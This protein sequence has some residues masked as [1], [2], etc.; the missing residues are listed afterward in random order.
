[1]WDGA[2]MPSPGISLLKIVFSRKGAPNYQ[3]P[4]LTWSTWGPNQGR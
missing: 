3:N 4:N 1:M 2:E